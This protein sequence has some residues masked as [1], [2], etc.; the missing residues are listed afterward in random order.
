[1]AKGRF[2]PDAAGPGDGWEDAVPPA[3]LAAATEA[4]SAEGEPRLSLMYA[5]A[6]LLAQGLG[7]VDAAAML[8]VSYSTFYRATSDPRFIVV[9]RHLLADSL[10]LEAAQKARRAFRVDRAYEVLESELDSK[11]EWLRHN[12]AVALIAAEKSDASKDR[13]RV[14]IIMSPA[15]GF[16]DQELDAESDDD[17][18]EEPEEDAE[19]PENAVNPVYLQQ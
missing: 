18:Q 4:V 10:G 15:M 2:R 1:V 11:N 14:E 6:R 16:D 3:V 9:Q 17:L 13:P 7:K 19:M 12:A 5:A 8:G